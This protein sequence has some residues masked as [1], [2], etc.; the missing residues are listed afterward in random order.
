MR[1]LLL[2][3]LVALMGDAGAAREAGGPQIVRRDH[4]EIGVPAHAA[5]GEPVLVQGRTTLWRGVMLSR[6]D[7]IRGYRF[8][9]GF[10]PQLREDEAFS[11]HDV[12]S[13]RG[14]EGH[15]M[16]RPSFDPFGAIN[17]VVALRAAKTHRQLC[18]IRRIGVRL[19]DT[20]TDYAL[21][22]REVDIADERRQTLIYGGHSGRRIRLSYRETGGGQAGTLSHEVEYD[23]GQSDEVRYRDARLRVLAV[24]DDG[25]DYVVIRGFGSP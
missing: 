21:V 13:G 10:Y 19:C 15:G 7:N 5:I 12:R 3:V 22:D 6:D 20:E 23:L 1:M 17:G 16:L 2:V 8:T 4:P 9:R 14:Q 18:V 24:D 25:I 11:Y